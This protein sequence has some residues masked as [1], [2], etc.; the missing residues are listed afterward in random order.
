MASQIFTRKDPATI[1]I[2]VQHELFLQA[3]LD[4][5]PIDHGSLAVT[6][7]H[8]EMGDARLGNIRVSA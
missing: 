3:L 1:V 8:V 4:D 7:G 2:P 6:V 5:Q